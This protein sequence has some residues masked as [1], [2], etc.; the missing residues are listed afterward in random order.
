[1]K[2]TTIVLKFNIVCDIYQLKDRCFVLLLYDL[3]L[4]TKNE[5]NKQNVRV[6]KRISEFKY[7]FG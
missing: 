7:C 5:M 4:L 3:K 1:M 2:L 6:L